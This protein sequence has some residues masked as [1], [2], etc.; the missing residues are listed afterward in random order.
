M[1]VNLKRGQNMK[2]KKGRKTKKHIFGKI[3]LAAIGVLLIWLISDICLTE[4]YAARIPHRFASAEEGRERLLANTEYYSQLT[5]TDLNYRLDHDNATLDELLERSTAEIKD[6]NI[7]EKY[8]VDR[9]IAKMAGKLAKNSY[10]L[11]LP[12]EI[13]FIKS[14]MSVEIM[15]ASGYTHGNDI[16]LNSTNIALSVIPEAGKYF[17]KLLWHELF[18]C[19]TRN[20]SDFR[21]QMYSLI[22][23]TVTDSDF[24]L[25]PCVRERYLSNPDVEHHDSYAAFTIDGQQVDCFLVWMAA[26]D[27]SETQ[28]GAGPE[29]ITALVPI[30]GTDI[31]Y[32]RD[33]AS[34]FDEVFGT[35][36][37]YVIDPEEC[38]ADNFAYAMYYGINGQ[39][40]QGYPNPEI[41]SG[42][43]DIVSR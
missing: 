30:D 23:F 26:G 18:H 11:P 24:E 22:H 43:I 5:Q 36:T 12:E 21:A 33:Q 34:D 16:Y 38:M 13:V 3:I 2:S 7:I 41:I 35:N 29:K 32:T 39:D 20:S 28:P 40:G 31:Y 1:T 14:D 9:R 8:L 25:P 4:I 17:D 42:I 6:Y 37:G 10:Q 15:T 19:L 27:Y